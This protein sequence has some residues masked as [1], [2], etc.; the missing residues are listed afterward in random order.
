MKE[1]NELVTENDWNF[2]KLSFLA[3]AAFTFICDIWFFTWKIF[4]VFTLGCFKQKLCSKSDKN[5]NLSS[6]LSPVSIFSVFLQ[7]LVTDFPFLRTSILSATS[8][9]QTKNGWLTLFSGRFIAGRFFRWHIWGCSFVRNDY[10]NSLLA[11][12]LKCP[13]IIFEVEIW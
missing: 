9:L 5:N 12:E 2:P 7:K 8:N 1:L 4:A 10:G 11:P 6:S 13:I 3:W